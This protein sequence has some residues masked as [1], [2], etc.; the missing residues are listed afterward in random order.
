MRPD[1]LRFSPELIKGLGTRDD[2]QYNMVRTLHQM[3]ADLGICTIADGLEHSEC[4]EACRDIGFQLL[5][6][7]AFG[8]QQLL[9]QLP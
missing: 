2:V 3:A 5:Q 7:P 9:D 4:I 8:R 1:F 6:G